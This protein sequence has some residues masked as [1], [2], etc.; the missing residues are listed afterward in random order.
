[1]AIGKPVIL[2]TQNNEDVPF[3]VRHMRYIQYSYTPRGMLEFEKRLAETI[4]T[5]LQLEQ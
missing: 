3:D 2:I 4:K 1:M 5:V